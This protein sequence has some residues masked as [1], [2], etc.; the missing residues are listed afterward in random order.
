MSRATDHSLLKREAYC[1]LADALGESP[2]TVTAVHHLY[3][4]HG[5]VYLVGNPKRFDAVLIENPA[6]E[7]WMGYGPDVN[8]LFALFQD[9]TRWDG[10]V[11]A[12]ALA[13]AL[14]QRI[15]QRMGIPVRYEDMLFH[16]LRKPVVI[17]RHPVV[18]QLTLRDAL[19]LETATEELRWTG[20]ESMHSL[21]RDGLVAAA[22]VEGHIVAIAHTSSRSRDYAEL[23]VGTL[24]AW[25]NRGLASAAAA[26][27]AHK[28][29][30]AGQV[31]VW[32]TSENNTASLRVAEKLGFT[33]EGCLTAVIL[34]RGRSGAHDDAPSAEKRCA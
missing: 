18:R 27:V 13:H 2:E 23:G 11:V 5:R 17:F 9:T 24:E 16:I 3:R 29:Q 20:F 14:G 31:P 19:L 4:G 30:E 21:L 33:R 26:L 12:P 6:S 25:R 32:S 22:L 10:I 8:A 28:V 7:E 1:A 34:Q 15:E